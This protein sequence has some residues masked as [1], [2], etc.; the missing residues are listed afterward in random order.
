MV[1]SVVGRWIEVSKADH[2]IARVSV[3]SFALFIVFAVLL[4]VIF[5]ALNFALAPLAKL[6]AVDR[7]SFVIT[8]SQKALSTV[9]AVLAFF[10]PGAG[11]LGLIVLP[12]I[13]CHF[14]Q[15]LMDGMMVNWWLKQRASASPSKAAAAAAAGS[16]EGGVSTVPGATAVTMVSASESDSAVVSGGGPVTALSHQIDQVVVDVEELGDGIV[17]A[18]RT[19][20]SDVADSNGALMGRLHADSFE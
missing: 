9:V 7:S 17:G 10:P 6:D 18:T 15:I 4:H 19:I 20:G 8:C 12:C 13:V 16:G 5:L 3:G 1:L 11:E 2:D 14:V